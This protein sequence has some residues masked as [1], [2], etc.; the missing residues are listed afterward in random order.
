MGGFDVLEVKPIHK[1]QGVLRC[2][3]H[4]FGLS[5]EWAATKALSVLL[6]PFVP[7]GVIAHM[8]LAVARKP[9]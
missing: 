3:H 4:E 6:Q 2:L 7:A 9:G 8:V 5:Y 1:R